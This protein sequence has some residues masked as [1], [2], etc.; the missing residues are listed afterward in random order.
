MFNFTVPKNSLDIVFKN[1]NNVKATFDLFSC[2]V[3]RTT[4]PVIILHKF[5]KQ[6]LSATLTDQ[7]QQKSS[8]DDITHHH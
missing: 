5:K 7:K 6:S 3:L 2:D 8:K 1:S 4:L